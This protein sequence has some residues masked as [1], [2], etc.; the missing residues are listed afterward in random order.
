VKRN[1]GTSLALYDDAIE[2]E[3]QRKFAITEELRDAIG[4][5]EMRVDGMVATQVSESQHGG[6]D[7]LLA[8]LA[9]GVLSAGDVDGWMSVDHVLRPRPGAAAGHDRRSEA[10]ATLYQSTKDVVHRLG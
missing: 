5:G 2:A 6:G 3:A 7:A 10:F 9:S 8:G 1:P 4:R